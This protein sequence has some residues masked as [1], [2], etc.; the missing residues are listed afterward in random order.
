MALSAVGLMLTP[1]TAA[2]PGPVTFS[3]VYQVRFVGLRLGKAEIRA[4]VDAKTY[5]VKGETKLSFLKRLVFELKGGVSATGKMASTG[6]R[7][8][9]YG[10]FFKTRK[11]K[12]HLN[13]AFKGNA[14]STVASQPV[15]KQH[16]RAIPLTKKHVRAVFDPLSAVF[17]AGKSMKDGMDTSVCSRRLPIFDGKHRY[18]VQL[19]HIKTVKVEPRGRKGYAGLALVCRAKYHPIAGHRPHHEA[20]T[21]MIQT[22]D[23]EAWLIPVPQANLY[24]PYHVVIP[25]PWGT[26]TLTA[27]TLEVEGVGKKKIALVR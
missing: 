15:I 16:R 20:V 27:K 8:A 25:T 14:V 17:L 6:P 10:L 12:G 24:V 3:A 2:E 18:D 22:N 1:A 4:K 9:S 26:A 7:P 23:I 19:S 21:F 5:D 11:K 13:M